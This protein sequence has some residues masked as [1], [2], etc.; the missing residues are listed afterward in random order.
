MFRIDRTRVK[1]S[2]MPGAQNLQA[3]VEQDAPL[4]APVQGPEMT[5]EFIR[6]QE[7]LTAEILARANTQAEEIKLEAQQLLKK[8]KNEAEAIQVS[9]RELGYNEGKTQA[10]SEYAQL[11][12][13]NNNALSRVMEEIASGRQTLLDEVEENIIDLCFDIIKKMATMDRAKDGDIFKGI[14]KKTLAQMDMEGKLILRLSVE[15]IERFFPEGEATFHLGDSLVKVSVVEDST[16][17]SGDTIVET[18]TEA[19]TAGIDSQMK[20]IELAFRQ[21]LGKSS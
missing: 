4:S 21:Q 8:A 14:I 13:D 19:I 16:L 11:I 15:D 1:I 12:N 5:E 20:N 6:L 7:D 10:E 9:A 2:G 18:E 17:R 3:N